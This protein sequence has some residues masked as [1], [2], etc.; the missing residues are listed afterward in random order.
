[1]AAALALPLTGVLL[2]DTQA[3]VAPSR[4]SAAPVAAKRAPN[5]RTPLSTFARSIGFEHTWVTPAKVL[6]VKS[7]LNELLFEADK[8]EVRLNG[9][10]LFMG[11]A[12][13]PGKKTLQITEIDRDR[14]LLPILAPQKL[15]AMQPLRLIAL[16]PGHGGR[17]RGTHSDAF[18]LDE[19]DLTLDVAKR[20]KPMLEARGFRVFLTRTDDT[21]IPLPDRP[22]LAAGAGADLFV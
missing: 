22:K 16:D 4:P 6:R 10:R 20:L 13:T 19:K 12:A 17:D 15:P 8:R 11:D 9:L 7:R 21:Y 14:F 18:N 3:R 1:M 5:A 2:G